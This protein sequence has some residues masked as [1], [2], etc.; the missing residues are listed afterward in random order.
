MPSEGSGSGGSG[1]SHSASP[2]VVLLQGDDEDT[3][4]G[5]EENAGHSEDK[6]ALSQVTVSLLD[7]STSNN[8]DTRKATACETACKSNIQ[9]GNWQDEQICQGKEGIAQCD[10]GVNDYT[11]GGRPRKVPDKIGPPFSYMEERGVFKPLDTIANPLGLCR[12][13]RTNPQ[14]SNI[15]TS[16]NSAVAACKIKHLLGRAKD[17]GWPLTIIIFEGSNVTSLGLLQ[18]LHS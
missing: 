9:Y 15:I 7:I 2:D 10:K 1:C 4:V 17:L 16:L 3:A 8:E 12:F 11:N 18:E 14:K 13:Y 5:G 6:E